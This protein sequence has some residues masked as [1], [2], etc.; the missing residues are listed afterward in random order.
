[1]GSEGSRKCRLEAERRTHAC[2][3]PALERGNVVVSERRI[4]DEEILW[5]VRD[6]KYVPA[7]GRLKSSGA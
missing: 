1:M 7:P 2:F 4:R 3:P 6:K 5:S